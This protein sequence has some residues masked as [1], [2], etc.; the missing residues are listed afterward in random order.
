MREFLQGLVPRREQNLGDPRS[1]WLRDVILPLTLS[2]S[3]TSSATSLWEWNP[4]GLLM[5]RSVPPLPTRTKGGRLSKAGSMARTM[6]GPPTWIPARST[7]RYVLRYRTVCRVWV[8]WRAREVAR[9][10]WTGDTRETHTAHPGEL[11]SFVHPDTR[12]FQARRDSARRCA[13]CW[14]QRMIRQTLPPPL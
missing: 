3:Q 4:A 12:M 9:L 7:S 5:S 10:A 2:L 13:N 8:D 14:D 6:A 1:L 11:P